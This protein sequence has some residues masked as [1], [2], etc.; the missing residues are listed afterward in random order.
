MLKTAN[1]IGLSGVTV[2][3]EFTGVETFVPCVPGKTSDG[4]HTFNELYEQRYLLFCGMLAAIATNPTPWTGEPWKSKL[5]HDGSE[6][7]GW[8]ICGLELN[9]KPITYHLPMRLWDVCKAVERDRAPEWDGHTSDDVLERL[10]KWLK[11]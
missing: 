2:V 3:S 5:H 6:W 11:S 9:N 1:S 7:E 10:M 8:F 4:H